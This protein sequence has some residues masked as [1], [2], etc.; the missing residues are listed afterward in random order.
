MSCSEY[1]ASTLL[2]F[3]ERLL[4]SFYLCRS[5]YVVLD[6]VPLELDCGLFCLRE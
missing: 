3:F 1:S 6:P 5:T 4:M 2:R